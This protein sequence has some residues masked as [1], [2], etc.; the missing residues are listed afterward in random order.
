MYYC[1]QQ[2]LK[3]IEKVL[4]NKKLFRY[5]GPG[6]ETECSSFEK[7]FAKYLNTENTLLV[8]SG[9][10]ALVNALFAAGIQEDDEV[11]VPSY[12][13]FATLAA[14]I[15]LK[16]IPVVANIDNSLSYDTTDLISKITSK[17]KALI[18]VHM[19]GHPA[20]MDTLLKI[21][22]DNNLILIEDVAQAVGGSY[23]E[24]KLGALGDLGCFSFNVDKIISCGEGGAVSINKKEY[25]QKAFMYHDTCNQFGTS[26]KDFYDIEKFSGKSMRVSEIQGAMINIQLQRLDTILKD[27]KERYQVLYKHLVDLGLQPIVDFDSDG[28]CHTTLRFLCTDANQVAKCVLKLNSFELECFSPTLRPAHTVWSWFNLFSKFSKQNKF[29]Y[30]SS[31]DILSRTLL[32]KVNLEGTLNDWIEKVKKLDRQ[33][34]Q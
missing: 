22:R 26:L 7:S 10:N 12:T 1:D 24:N 13:F 20:D 19:D 23:K 6:V 31:M 17:T 34:L 11:L 21:A 32:I 8:S 2:E 28:N 25:L 29:D 33:S 18:V 15:E 3:A 9:T 5:Q 16:A 27:L 14:V 30:I 4:M